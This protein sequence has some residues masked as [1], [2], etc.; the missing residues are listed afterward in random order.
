EIEQSIEDSK[1]LEEQVAPLLTKM[2][3]ALDQF[4]SADLP[5]HIED[6]KESI[7]RL[8][9]LMTNPEARTSDRFRNIMDIYTAE[10]EYG[11]TFEAYRGDIDING[12]STPVDVLRIGRL[13][14]YAQTDDRKQSFMYNK[15][16]GSWDPIDN[17]R[18]IRTAIKV[19][20]K[21]VAPELLNLPIPAPEDA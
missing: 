15:A 10:I 12:E 14:L 4:V 8:K 19:A 17:H 21:T 13:A 9:A 1:G 5:F 3:S 7:G 16:G 11:N 20:S 18:D 6:R 2:L